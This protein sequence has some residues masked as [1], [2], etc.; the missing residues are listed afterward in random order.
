MDDE[1]VAPPKPHP[2]LWVGSVAENGFSPR[3]VMGDMRSSA[4]PSAPNP[5][6]GP[7]VAPPNPKPDESAP[8]EGDEEDMAPPKPNPD[9]AASAVHA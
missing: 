8:N 5:Y 3:T 9:V 2:L 7:E 6:P 1:A 4:A